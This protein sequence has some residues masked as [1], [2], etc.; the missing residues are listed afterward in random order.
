[1][2]KYLPQNNQYIFY[3]KQFGQ[4][5]LKEKGQTLNLCDMGIK[6]QFW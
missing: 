5:S 2:G 4:I 1:M 6:H 3:Y